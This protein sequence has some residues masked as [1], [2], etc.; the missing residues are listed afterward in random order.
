M[1]GVPKGEPYAEQKLA[2]QYQ[3]GA[4][5]SYD[6]ETRNFFH[7]DQVYSGLTR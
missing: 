6:V 3:T 2:M 5:G 1:A 7:L 4:A